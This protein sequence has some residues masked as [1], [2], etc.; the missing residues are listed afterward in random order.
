MSEVVH[1]LHTAL[2]FPMKATLLVAIQKGNLVTFP[3]MT[4]DN[5]VRFFPE[6]EETQKEHMRQ[7]HQVVHSTKTK[8]FD[9]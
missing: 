6:S 2:G 7:T 8:D 5:I 4:K 9:E 1:F 3:G